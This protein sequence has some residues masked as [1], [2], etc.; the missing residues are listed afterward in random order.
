MC[1]KL[2]WVAVWACEPARALFYFVPSR[3]NSPDALPSPVP[4]RM[5]T[6][7]TAGASIVGHC[8]ELRGL[9]H[10]ASDLH[11]TNAVVLKQ[12][13]TSLKKGPGLKQGA[14]KKA[15]ALKRG[16][17]VADFASKKAVRTSKKTSKTKT[18]A[19]KQVGV[20]VADVG[21]ANYYEPTKMDPTVAANRH[22]A[23]EN[24]KKKAQ[25][26]IDSS[27]M[28]KDHTIFYLDFLEVVSEKGWGGQAD[29]HGF[30]SNEN[31]M[32]Y[33]KEHLTTR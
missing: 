2:V 20:A 21:K 23:M 16:A 17:T 9:V 24:L 6:R 3:S 22:K 13:R 33:F 31:V 25:L 26:M 12:G 15:T 18:K 27:G 32:R 8:S 1:C 28:S 14:K 19:L 4:T 7:N 5:P 11:R 29:R 30:A 10:A